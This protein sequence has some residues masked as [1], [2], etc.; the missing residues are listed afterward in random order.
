M[1]EVKVN[2]R[3]VLWALIFAVSFS[4]SVFILAKYSI[5]VSIALLIIAINSLL[6]GVYTVRLVQSISYMDEVQIR[7]QLEAVS[8]AFVLSLFLV[9]ILGMA[10]LV[11]NL[12]LDNISYLYVFPL[13]FMFYIIGFF[14]S[15]RKY[16]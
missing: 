11:R 2:Q 4:I 14:F 9:M 7:I 3:S 8:V 1:K 12:G 10:G 6:F 13:F 16:R 5:P 15:K